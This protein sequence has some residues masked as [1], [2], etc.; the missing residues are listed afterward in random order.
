MDG[1]TREAL[2]ERAA[3]PLAYVD[4]LVE[5]G[6][7][8]L[9]EQ[10]SFFS[11]GDL[12]RTR[13]VR[14]LEEGGLPLEGIATAVRNGDL[15]FRFLD[16]ESWGWYGGFVGK[17]YGE[18]SAETGVPLEMLQVVRE[19]M[20]FARPDQDRR[21]GDRDAR[22]EAG[23]VPRSGRQHPVGDRGVER[24]S[25]TREPT[26]RICDRREPSCPVDASQ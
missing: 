18:L 19:S 13:L 20:G 26:G 22:P 2:S 16:L 21:E 24:V 11:E 1:H 9:P 6:I 17:T 4:H 5:L 15:S 14:G 3:V 10:G 12:R 8:A 23:M 25:V 7:L